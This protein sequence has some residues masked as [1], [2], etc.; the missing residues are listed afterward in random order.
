[1]GLKKFVNNLRYLARYDLKDIWRRLNELQNKSKS[2]DYE[3]LIET[4]LYEVPNS[5]IRRPKILSVDETI[6][7]ILHTNKSIARF[8]DGEIMVADGQDILFQRAEL[9]LS[10]RLQ[11]ILAKPQENLMV[12]L[13]G[14]L[15]NPSSIVGEKN[16]MY[17]EFALYAVPSLRRKTA[18]FVNYDMIYY[19]T[20][21]SGARFEDYRGFFKGKKT[22]ACGLQRSF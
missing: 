3:Q 12:A 10:R 15:G 19:N 4:I 6:D 2:L 14:Y 17:K 21:A 20:G 1:M 16:P 8:G 11:E 22:R 7:E 9:G 5:G 13:S 18:K